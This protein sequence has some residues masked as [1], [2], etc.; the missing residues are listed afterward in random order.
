MHIGELEEL[1]LL[2]IR[3][4]GADAYGIPV[5]T[6]IAEAGRDISVG[7]LYITL[8]RL[9]TKGLVEGRQGE[10][11]P[12]RGGRPKR[13]FRLTGEGEAALQNIEAIRTRLAAPSRL[14]GGTT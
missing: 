10:I 5:R 6:A 8:D 13:Y 4:L 14:I 3:Q 1:I 7:T 11:T 9:E 2:A 12:E